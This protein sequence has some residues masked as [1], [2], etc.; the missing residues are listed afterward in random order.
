MV[1]HLLER[2]LVTSKEVLWEMLPAVLRH[3]GRRERRGGEAGEAGRAE[4]EC[5]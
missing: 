4:G 5:R 3:V 1:L 2:K